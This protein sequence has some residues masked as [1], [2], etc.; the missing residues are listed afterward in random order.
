[1]A[2]DF[3]R[4]LNIRSAI[5][6][7]FISDSERVAFL[8]DVSGNYQVWQI[9]IGAGQAEHFPQQLTFLPD[10]V[11]ELHAS[12]SGDLLVVSDANGNENQQFY[13]IAGIKEG[14][15]TIRRLT[16]DDN[17]IYRF[18][19]WS[20][21]GGQLVFACNARSRIDFDLWW[22]DVHTGESWMIH[23]TT[24]NRTIADWSADGRYVV[25]V[26]ELS[27]LHMQVFVLDIQTGEECQLTS[28]HP[29]AYYPV[30]YFVETAPSATELYCLTDR[31]SDRSALCK[32]DMLTGE[33]SEIIR[34]EDLTDNGEIE[35]F[36]VSADGQ[37]IALVLN[38]D[39]FNTIH[40]LNLQTHERREVATP[41]VGVVGALHFDADGRRL[42]INWQSATQN[43]NVYV[44]EIGSGNR[45]GVGSRPT[46]EKSSSGS[47]EGTAV[48]STQLTYFDRAGIAGESFVPPQL[49]RFPSFDGL[50][51][52][53]WYFMPKT[54]KPA[55]GYPCILYVHGGPAMQLRPE[56]DVRFQ[57]FLNHGYAILATNVRGS[58][59]YGR[60]YTALDEVEKR[61]DSV[62]D[63]KYAVEWLHQQPNI[64][65]KR[66]GIYGR[67]YGGFMVLA[68]ITEYPD[69]FAAAV[70]VVG[71][72][73]WVTF[74]E[75]T[76]A[77][78]RAHR[79]S[80]YGSLVQ[81]RALLERLSP[82]HKIERVRCPLHV[83]AG[84]NDPRVPL[85]ESEQ[86]AE[87]VKA[88]G[89]TVEFVHYADEG[90]MFSKLVNRVDSFTK[91]AAFLERYL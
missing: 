15:H 26:L 23:E 29:D 87:R 48:E 68:A 5:S 79:E 39:G 16:L 2:H 33:L 22:M 42:V 3:T 50:Q 40:L 35:S 64:D 30:L 34:S 85:Y 60:I 36:V 25:S 58:T 78:R 21:S 91:M 62:T 24:G 76:A 52:P 38:E 11:W 27:S 44:L 90:H 31:T 71:I 59:G 10:K 82:I 80:E 41:G 37:M 4:Y 88:N 61:M 73:N 86:L 89:G 6:P 69:L 56:F 17:V 43:S 8:S 1:M 75:K 70:D 54:T 81:H 67:S 83:Q 20:K 72:A 13:L 32:L 47:G 46:R 77:W 9:G 14:D 45:V 66:I 63:L 65:R 12:P 18:G 55:A 57:Y 74:L 51:I 49:I 28:G 84:D 53:A 7:T 19:A